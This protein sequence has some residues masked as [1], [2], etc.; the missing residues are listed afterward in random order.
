MIEIDIYASVIHCVP[1]KNAFNN[2]F[3]SVSILGQRL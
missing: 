3:G 2:A 1:S